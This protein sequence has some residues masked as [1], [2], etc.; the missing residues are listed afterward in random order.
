[1]HPSW[2]EVLSD[3]E[4][5]IRRQGDFLR[6][7]IA[8]GRRY[9]PGGAAVFRALHT[10]F[11]QVK[12]LL[13]GQDPYP[14]PG[15]PVG[16]SFA[17]APGTP[18]PA[19]LRN[20][21]I[22]LADDLGVSLPVDL[23]VWAQRGVL[24]LNRVLTVQPGKPGSHRNHGWEPLTARMVEVLATRNQPLVAILWGRD[25]QSVRNLLGDYPVVAS[26]HPSP[27]SAHRGFFG[28]RPFSRVNDLLRQQGEA[29]IDWD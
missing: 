28:S 4:P 24:M 6:A 1:M 29:P 26:A 11:D 27:L 9:Q 14:T 7:E 18:V 17:V 15:V 25:A 5:A 19:S 8:A 21:A 2:A 16:L 22:E 12:V 20:I 13:L 23:S 3:W 10:P